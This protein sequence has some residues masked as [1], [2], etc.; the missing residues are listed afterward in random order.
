MS[1]SYL[2]LKETNQQCFEGFAMLIVHIEKK[3][4]LNPNPTPN[5]FGCEIQ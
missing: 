3:T 4:K 5:A 2:K 1:N